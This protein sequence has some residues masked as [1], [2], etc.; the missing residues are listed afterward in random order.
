MHYSN[1][2]SSIYG[3]SQCKVQAA[4]QSWQNSP[5]V[6]LQ[7]LLGLLDMRGGVRL[8]SATFHNGQIIKCMRFGIC[9][10]KYTV[11]AMEPSAGYTSSKSTPENGNAKRLVRGSRNG[12]VHNAQLNQLY[13]Y[14]YL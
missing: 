13:K 2:T 8:R 1:L 3:R 10:G 11:E 5:F 12:L 9:E 4:F 6:V 7:T 14:T